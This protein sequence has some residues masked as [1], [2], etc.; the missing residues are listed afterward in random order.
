MGRE[1]PGKDDYLISESNLTEI[2][3]YLLLEIPFCFLIFRR[4][5]RESV[6]RKGFW[7]AQ[8]LLPIMFAMEKYQGKNALYYL[9]L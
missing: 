3:G 2:S 9:A 1:G 6:P 5:H 7:N 8:N 4:S